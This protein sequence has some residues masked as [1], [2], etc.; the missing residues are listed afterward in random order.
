MPEGGGWS[1]SIAWL[2]RFGKRVVGA[3]VLTVVVEEL[4][5]LDVVVATFVVLVRGALLLAGS[6]VVV[7]E[8]DGAV[9]GEAVVVAL[10]AVTAVG[11][12]VAVEAG[13]VV[14]AGRLTPL[15]G[16]C[17]RRLAAWWLAP[18]PATSTATVAAPKAI[19]GALVA[20]CLGLVTPL[21]VPLGE[22]HYWRST[23]RA[24]LLAP[25]TGPQ[26][27]AHGPL[28]P[29]GQGGLLARVVPVV[30]ARSALHEADRAPSK[31]P[32]PAP[33]HGVRRCRASWVPRRRAGHEPAGDDVPLVCRRIDS[34][35]K[36]IAA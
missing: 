22:P 3:E 2:T 5:A 12:A 16:R 8:R 27:I 29:P 26:S 1:A 35:A 4:S 9:A 23:R 19:A 20:P 28:V 24:P 32:W 18:H 13:A 7:A 31:T 34:W 21:L 17:A 30:A 6:A 10:E 11:A 25:R 15:T 36:P 14:L 33:A